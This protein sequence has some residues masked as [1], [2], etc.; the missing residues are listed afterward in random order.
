MPGFRQGTKRAG[1]DHES[2]EKIA[3]MHAA[4]DEDREKALAAIRP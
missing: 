4:Y 3:F 2:F 1:R